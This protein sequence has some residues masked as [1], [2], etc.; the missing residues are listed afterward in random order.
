MLKMNNLRILLLT[1][2]NSKIKNNN[3]VQINKELRKL[4]KYNLSN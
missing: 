1:I 2:Y 3:K 4:L